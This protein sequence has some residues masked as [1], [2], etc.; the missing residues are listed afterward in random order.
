MEP[1]LQ[2]RDAYEILGLSRSAASEDVRNS[3]RRLALRYHPDVAVGDDREEAQRAFVRLSKAYEVLQDPV[4]RQRYDRLLAVGVVPDLDLEIPDEP[5]P[6]GFR[7]ILCEIDLLNIPADESSLLRKVDARLRS[8]IEPNLYHDGPNRIERVLD[9]TRFYRL[10]DRAGFDKPSGKLIEGWLVVTNIRLIMLSWNTH[11]YES[12]NTRYTNH[13]PALVGLLF[14]SLKHLRL[15]SSG[16]TRSRDKLEAEDKSGTRFTIDFPASKIPRLLL[17]TGAYRLPL[18]VRVR[19]RPRRAL[20]LAAA[21]GLCPALAWSLPFLVLALIW[22]LTG[23]QVSASDFRSCYSWLTENHF[24]TAALYLTGPMLAYQWLR[25]DRTWNDR[26]RADEV[27]G[28]L[29]TDYALGRDATTQAFEGGGPL[30]AVPEPEDLA[31]Q[32]LTARLAEEGAPATLTTA[33]PPM[34]RV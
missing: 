3:F 24:T 13:H 32:W 2:A 34:T 31:V 8:L 10:I 11:V 9:V 12:G 33:A 28:R 14:V 6:R 23:G 30:A 1:D 17:I 29:P 21:K 18:R 22:V 19:P 4:T 27:L 16:R 15:Y 7:E 25:F 20:A 26:V 5:P